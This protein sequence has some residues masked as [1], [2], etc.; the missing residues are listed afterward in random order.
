MARPS[1]FDREEALDVV[2]NSVWRDG[3]KDSSVKAL[4]EQLNITRS[5]FYNAFGSQAALFREVLQRYGADPRQ[6]G[7]YSIDRDESLKVGLSKYFESLC[8]ARA[9]DPEHRGCLVTNCVAELLPGETEMATFV[10]EMVE[11]GLQMFA[12]RIERAV[13][14]GELPNQTDARALSLA[15]HSLVLGT[16]LLSK[17]EHDG[18]RLWNTC[19]P[20]LQALE[21]YAPSIE[22]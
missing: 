4:S 9:D 6:S 5:S 1:K 13:E 16:N 2:M 12:Q 10:S 11:G 3:I 17:V 20:T 15:V 14:V 7:L 19:K 21:L 18:E 8:R 22:P